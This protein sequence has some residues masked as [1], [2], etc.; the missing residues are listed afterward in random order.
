MSG[1]TEP[2]ATVRRE[3]FG[4]EAGGAAT[5]S[6]SKFRSF[7]KGR[8]KR[9]YAVVTVAGT[10]A[11]H[12]LDVFHGTTSIG[13]IALG[14]SAVGVTASSAILNEELLSLDQISVKSG[15]DITGKAEVVYEYHVHH[16]AVKT[17]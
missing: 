10:N 2:N 12:K 8:L 13:T 3:F 9:V 1:Y 16:D 17:K 14:V 6:Y 15:A 7:Q 11:G 4:G 5:T